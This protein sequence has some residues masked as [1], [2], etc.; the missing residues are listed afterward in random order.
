MNAAEIEQA[1]T[2]LAEQE[3][4]SESFPYAFSERLEKLFDLYTK[5]TAK[6]RSSG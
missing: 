3:F 4:D 6:G 1:I 2:E 5:M